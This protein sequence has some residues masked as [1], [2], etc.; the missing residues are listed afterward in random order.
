MWKKAK[1]VSNETIENENVENENELNNNQP[2]TENDAEN[3]QTNET[4]GENENVEND[5]KKKIQNTSMDRVHVVAKYNN[6]S[7]EKGCEYEISR[8]VLENYNGL[9]DVL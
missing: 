4:N 5:L 8:K 2:E 9:F 1:N 3:S 6:G 7:F